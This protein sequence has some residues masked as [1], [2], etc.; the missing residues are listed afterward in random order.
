MA[1]AASKPTYLILVAGGNYQERESWINAE[2]STSREQSVV[3]TGIILEGL[4]SGI[5]PLQSHPS[6]IVERIAPGCF[7][8]IGNLVLRVTLNRMLRQKPECLYL[9]MNNQEH[10]GSLKNFL[11]SEPYIDLFTFEREV[12]L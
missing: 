11:E 6:L 1:N 3:K 8:C 5:M 4:P 7:C 9:A 12:I 2:L 10:L